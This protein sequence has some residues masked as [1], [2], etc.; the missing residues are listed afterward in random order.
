M[1]NFHPVG[2][3][4]WLGR[5]KL[6]SLIGGGILAEGGALGTHDVSR[7]LLAWHDGELPR[8]I[9]PLNFVNHEPHQA[10]LRHLNELAVIGNLGITNLPSNPSSIQF[11]HAEIPA[12]QSARVDP[13]T[14]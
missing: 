14:I 2:Q 12:I 4:H 6:I 7:G 9:H 1:A 13:D 11:Q 8:N 10:P 3:F 5:K